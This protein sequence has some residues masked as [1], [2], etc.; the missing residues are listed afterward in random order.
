M[1]KDFEK[2]AFPFYYCNLIETFINNMHISPLPK[3]GG[4]NMANERNKVKF[5]TVNAEKVNFGRNNF[6]EVARRRAITD[7][8][9]NEFISI[10][11][12]YYLGD[13]TEVFKKSL[14]IPDTEEVKKFVAEKILSL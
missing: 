13:E 10:S 6:I 7:E 14:T 8:G 3:N 5:D 9:E 12:G 4:K 1:K 11:R 2:F